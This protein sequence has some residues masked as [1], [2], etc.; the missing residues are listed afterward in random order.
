LHIQIVYFSLAVHNQSSFPVLRSQLIA[1]T[2]DRNHMTNIS[3][4]QV[5]A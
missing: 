1:H 2:E 4:S 3:L 5:K